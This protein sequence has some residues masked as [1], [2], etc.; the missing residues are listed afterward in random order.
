MQ[1]ITIPFF[2]LMLGHTMIR[3]MSMNDLSYLMDIDTITEPTSSIFN[4]NEE[5]RKIRL[6]FNALRILAEVQAAQIHHRSQIQYY[7]IPDFSDTQNETR[8]FCRYGCSKSYTDHASRSRHEKYKHPETFPY[9]CKACK[10]PF[11][12]A[13]AKKAHEATCSTPCGQD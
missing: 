8:L 9:H 7:Q 12:L 5:E 3:P 11:I 1:H 4:S 2:I 10:R 6:R 13:D